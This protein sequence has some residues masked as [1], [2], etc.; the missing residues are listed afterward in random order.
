M[1]TAI[2]MREFH[3]LTT[4]GGMP[5]DEAIEFINKAASAAKGVSHQSPHKVSFPDLPAGVPHNQRPP[6]LFQ[7]RQSR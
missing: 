3:I 1:T 5:A 7:P 6:A 2:L 4:V